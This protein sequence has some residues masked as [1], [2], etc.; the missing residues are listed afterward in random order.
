MPDVRV[1]S[2][3][4]CDAKV[5]GQERL[6]TLRHRVGL[7]ILLH[8]S[9]RETYQGVGASRVCRYMGFQEVQG[10]APGFDS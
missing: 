10:P 3:R 2:V 9:S 8:H 7:V 6:F 1:H 4:S 5:Q